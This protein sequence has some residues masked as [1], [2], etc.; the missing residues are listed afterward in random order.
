MGENVYR[1][2][3]ILSRK[4]QLVPYLAELIRTG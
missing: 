2:K 3:G 1:L 4:K